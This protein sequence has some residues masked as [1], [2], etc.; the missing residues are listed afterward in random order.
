MRSLRVG[1]AGVGVVGRGVAKGLLAKSP[2][3]EA[4]GVR[5]RL[6]AAA[7]PIWTPASKKIVPTALRRKDAFALA[8]DAGID[9]LVVAVGGVDL[10]ERLIRA[11][12]EAGK[13]VVTSNKAVLAEKGKGLFALAVREGKELSFESAVAGGIPI[14]LAIRGGFAANRISR[15]TAI[16]NGT[17]N[18]VL[19]RMEEDGLSLADAVRVAQERGFAE[20]DPT[21]DI[22][23]ADA[24]HKLSLLAGLLF[25]RHLPPKGIPRQGI[26]RILPDDFAFA[27]RWGFGIRSVARLAETPQGRAPG[28][29]LAAVVTPA[30]LPERSSLVHVRN[31]TNAIHLVGDLVGPALL[32]GLGAG[33]GPTASAILADLVEIARSAPHPPP[34]GYASRMAA[35][36]PARLVAPAAQS[37]RYYVRILA[38]DQPGVLAQVTR[39]F[40]RNRISL[41]AVF[42]RAGTGAGRAPVPVALLTHETTQE[43]I[44]RAAAALDRVRALR[45]RAVVWPVIEA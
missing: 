9:V 1:L 11:G 22:S 17:T 24:A 8:R 27:R 35:S 3:W 12:L 31:E 7:D 38:S 26:E 16:L 5:L 39:I 30:L 34:G 13:S 18:F 21:L 14:L 44:L 41:A 32:S 43:R 28:G 42:Q 29:R 4:E 37:N 19:T 33:E 10:P 6:A 45:P 36:T 25:R 40:G 23:G 20:A 2:A 15:V